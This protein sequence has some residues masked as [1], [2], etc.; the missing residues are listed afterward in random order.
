MSNLIY[1]SLEDI[2]TTKRTKL[3]ITTEVMKQCFKNKADRISSRV[4]RF[5]FERMVRMTKG[6]N[7]RLVNEAADAIYNIVSEFSTR[8][9][10]NEGVNVEMFINDFEMIKDVKYSK[11]TPFS[12][13]QIHYKFE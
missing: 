2:Y 4:Y 9:N 12:S 3:V 7:L 8:D 6:S 13:H 11:A 5:L 1:Y 10:K